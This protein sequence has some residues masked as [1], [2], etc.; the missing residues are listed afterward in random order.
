[1]KKLMIAVLM[2][3]MSGGVALAD[4]EGMAEAHVYVE[5]VANVAV[6]VITSNVDLGQVQNG[7][8]PAHVIFRVDANVEQVNLCVIATDLYKGD[9]PESIFII[10][11]K[12]DSTDD[13]ALVTPSNANPVA[14]QSSLLEWLARTE[15]NGLGAWESVCRE[16]ESGQ[17]G[18]FSMD[19]EVWVEYDQIDPELPMGEYSGFIKLICDIVPPDPGTVIN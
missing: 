5:V 8:F 7:V 6:G 10:P 1:M 17:G 16:Y 18:H 11:V 12:A 2:L 19:V 9:D 3:A 15:L 13:G 4:L 14:G